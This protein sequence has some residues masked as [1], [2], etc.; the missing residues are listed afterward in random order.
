MD[1]PR[2]VTLPILVNI[3]DK[4]ENLTHNTNEISSSM[5]NSKWEKETFPFKTN[6]RFAPNYQMGDVTILKNTA[7]TKGP[8][9]RHNSHREARMKQSKI[10]I[11]K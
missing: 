10:T 9:Y 5:T 7:C 3:P 4:V 1:Q 11:G 8:M 2:V 6:M